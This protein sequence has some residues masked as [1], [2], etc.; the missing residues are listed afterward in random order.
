MDDSKDIRGTMSGESPWAECKR[1]TQRAAGVWAGD[2][3]RLL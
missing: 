3:A 1:A 2:E